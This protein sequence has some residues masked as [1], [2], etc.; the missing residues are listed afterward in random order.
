[1]TLTDILK[2]QHRLHF[3]HI[4]IKVFYCA[5]LPH[6]VV[7]VSNKLI[8]KKCIHSL[9][10]F[11]LFRGRHFCFSEQNPTENRRC[12]WMIRWRQVS[13]T[14]AKE[15]KDSMEEFYTV[16]KFPPLPLCWRSARWIVA[17]SS[18]S[19]LHSLAIFYKITKFG[20]YWISIVDKKFSDKILKYKFKMADKN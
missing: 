6:H 12:C 8:N 7:V 20:N 11:Y 9:T 4:H 14:A 13:W 18:C 10:S 17:R 5:I 19:T 2:H 3:L 1:M 15:T 16:M